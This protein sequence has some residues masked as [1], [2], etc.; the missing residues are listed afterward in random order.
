MNRA[1]RARRKNSAV[2]GSSSVA[3]SS[4]EVVKVPGVPM[5]IMCSVNSDLRPIDYFCIG[6]AQA[7]VRVAEPDISEAV[8]A[9]LCTAHREDFHRATIVVL[10]ESIRMLKARWSTPAAQR[11]LADL[12]SS[13]SPADQQMAEARQQELE[14]LFCEIEAYDPALAERLRRC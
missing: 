13:L 3:K 10:A 8:V 1:N 9:R 2:R 5:C 7:A 14:S 4:S 12:Q 6:V 11:E